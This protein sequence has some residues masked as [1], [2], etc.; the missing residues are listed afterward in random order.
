MRDR[1]PMS[2]STHSSSPS[3]VMAH[4]SFGES[5]WASPVHYAQTRLS[6]SSSCMRV[7]CVHACG[8][9][10]CVVD[11]CAF[12]IGCLV[13][14]EYLDAAM[15]QIS[16][17]TAMIIFAAVGFV[18]FTRRGNDGKASACMQ[19]I[20][21]FTFLIFVSTSNK[22]CCEACLRRSA[23]VVCCAGAQ[24]VSR[25]TLCNRSTFEFPL[26]LCFWSKV[27][28]KPYLHRS[29]PFSTASS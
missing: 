26:C 1:R 21:I 28:P 9:F 27:L 17:P 24:R 23:L 29:S 5:A 25:A 6:H 10:G 2:I 15:I 13:N 16:V 19:F 20:I 12:S 8:V 7:G 11:G 3:S 14:V 4:W 22:V 18:I